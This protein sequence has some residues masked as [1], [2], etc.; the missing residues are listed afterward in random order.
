MESTTKKIEEKREITCA[1]VTGK[2]KAVAI[3]EMKNGTDL[4]PLEAI[5]I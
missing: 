4:K 5:Q 3:D 1:A 2:G